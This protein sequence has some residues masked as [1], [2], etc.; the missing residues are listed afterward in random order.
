MLIVEILDN[1]MKKF[2]VMNLRIDIFIVLMLLYGCNSVIITDGTMNIEEVLR[3]EKEASVSDV[4][5][6][7]VCIPLET[8]LQSLLPKNSRVASISDSLIVVQGGENIF[9]FSKSGKFITS[10]NHKGNGPNQYTNIKSMAVA[11]DQRMI[12]VLDFNTKI[13]FYD[14]NGVSHSSVYLGNDCIDLNSLGY[15]GNGR[16]IACGKLNKNEPTDCI[17]RFTDSGEIINK[18]KLDLNRGDLSENTFYSIST[19]YYH[20]SKT[21]LRQDFTSHLFSVDD[22]TVSP[23]ININAGKYNADSDLINDVRNRDRLY[24]EF[25]TCIQASESDRYWFLLYIFENTLRTIIID[26]KENTLI[27]SKDMEGIPKNS[28]GMKL[29]GSSRFWPSLVTDSFAASL[30]Y[31]PEEEGLDEN[32]SSVYIVYFNK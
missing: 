15:E 4:S 21:I 1:P 11:F 28:I 20:N 14:F 13:L 24:Q 8:T 10:L 32:N 6:K 23:Y 5:N 31:N 18:I 9:I 29:N 12:G 30:V 26:K 2:I 22:S 7:V 27:M 19:F 25:A 17:I 3:T 16:W